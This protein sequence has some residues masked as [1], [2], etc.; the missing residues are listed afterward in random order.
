MCNVSN[1]YNV[2]VC[3]VFSNLQCL[4]PSYCDSKANV[5]PSQILIIFSDEEPIKCV[6]VC[7]CVCDIYIY[8][9]HLPVKMCLPAAS[10]R[11]LVI[12]LEWPNSNV[13]VCVCV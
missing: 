6:C 2:C 11:I 5:R 1:V 13:C 8:K 3:N 12:A 10:T 9:Y 4:S 7:V